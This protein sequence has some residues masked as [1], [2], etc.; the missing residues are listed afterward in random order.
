[1]Q[2]KPGPKEN[3]DHA[4]LDMRVGVPTTNPLFQTKNFKPEYEMD[5]RLVASPIAMTCTLVVNPARYA[6]DQN[7]NDLFPMYCFDDDSYLRLATTPDTT[8]QLNDIQMFQNRAVAKDVKVIFN[9]H[10]VSA[11]KVTL[12]EPLSPADTAA[13]KPAGNAVPQ[14]YTRHTRR[15]QA[16]GGEAGWSRLPHGRGRAQGSGHDLCDRRDS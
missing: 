4:K 1:M 15:S 11:I 5:G 16:G 2:A 10:L 7:P 6:G 8:I 3:F 13:V 12:L 9:K 14:P